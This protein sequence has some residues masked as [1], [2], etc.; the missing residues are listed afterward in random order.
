MKPKPPSVEEIPK[1]KV[2]R[3][4]RKGNAL[5]PKTQAGRVI[6]KFGG[7]EVFVKALKSVG[8]PRHSSTIR[9]W[10]YPKSREGRGGVIPTGALRDILMAARNEGVL[11][12][13]DDLDPRVS[14]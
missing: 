12:T 10:S 7:L 2:G 8:H 13:K 14:K 5:N 9:K 11:L 3:R 4:H 1:P 6:T